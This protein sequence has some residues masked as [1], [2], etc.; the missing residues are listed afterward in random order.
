MKTLGPETISKLTI[1]PLFDFMASVQGTHNLGNDAIRQAMDGYLSKFRIRTGEDESFITYLSPHER[2]EFKNALL[3]LEHHFEAPDHLGESEE[4]SKG[5]IQKIMAAIRVVKPTLA[6]P[7]L[8]LR[9]ENRDGTWELAGFNKVGFDIY[10]A[11]EEDLEPFDAADLAILLKMMPRVYD[12]YSTHGG[13]RFNRVANA[14][15]FF[16][17]GYRLFVVDVRFVIF[18]T[19]L[20]SLFVTSDRRMGYQFRERISRFLTSEPLERQHLHDTCRE[21]YKIRSAIVHGGAVPGGVEVLHESM[22]LLQDI[23]RRCLQRILQDDL[24]FSR[25]QTGAMELG[26]FL[27]QIP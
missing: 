13:E 25:F 19:S 3:C 6:K 12:A 9:W 27:S 2:D 16:E 8:I 17:M 14:L 20:E 7:G 26:G 23:G 18:T 1:A 24:T 15:N 4:R 22:L 10:T 5:E 21:I 11:R